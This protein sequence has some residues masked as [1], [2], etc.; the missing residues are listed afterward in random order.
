MFC[1]FEDAFM[2]S[3]EQEKL[4][5]QTLRKVQTEA[6]EKKEC[7][8]CANTYFK[9]WNNHGHLD[10]TKHCKFSKECIDFENGKNC[11]N[12]KPRELAEMML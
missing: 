11:Q 10:H 8:M 4:W 3:K 1:S 6:I 9:P 2:P 12:W 7:W 5:E